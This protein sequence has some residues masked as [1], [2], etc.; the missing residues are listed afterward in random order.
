MAWLS[1]GEFVLQARAVQR[2]GLDFVTALNNGFVPS[3]KGLSG[4]S[5]GGVVDNFNRSMSVP[6]YASGGLAKL[7]SAS[8][9]TTQ[10][11]TPLLLQFNGGEVIDDITIGNI[12]MNRLQREWTQHQL[13]KT[14]RRPSSR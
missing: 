3:L 2:L 13:L 6:R 5:L 10:G 12:A 11:R 4:F 9:S 7:A 8:A 14:G 1:N